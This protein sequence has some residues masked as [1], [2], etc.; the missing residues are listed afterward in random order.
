MGDTTELSILPIYSAYRWSNGN[1]GNSFTTS[2]SG[3][4]LIE[5][6]DASGCS[7]KDSINFVVHNFPAQL[8]SA[9]TEFKFCE[10][11]PL[12]L[13]G[14]A[15]MATYLWS[16]G[17]S[18]SQITVNSVGKIALKVINEIGCTATS[19]TILIE[20]I[21]DAA[22]CEALQINPGLAYLNKFIQVAP[23][24]LTEY[25][26]FQIYSPQSQFVNLKLLIQEVQKLQRFLKVK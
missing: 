4:Y 19:D 25:T 7:S 1:I 21:T 18:S 11:K 13:K 15:N 6:K 17:E 3:K 5:V 10:G 26:I 9:T 23:N 16:T 20:Q 8:I 24:P 12:T 14:P 2:V 22:E